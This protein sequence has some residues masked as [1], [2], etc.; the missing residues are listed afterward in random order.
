MNKLVIHGI[1]RHYKGDYYIVE[2]VVHHS[3]TDE[4]LVVYRGLYDNGKMHCARP[5][6][7][8]L[9]EIDPTK[10]P[11]GLP[12]QKYRFQLQEIPSVAVH[13]R[14]PNSPD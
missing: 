8:F 11:E 10:I 14:R 1:Y 13:W 3:E 7:M 4:E 2:D 5:K 6:D 12:A 9:S